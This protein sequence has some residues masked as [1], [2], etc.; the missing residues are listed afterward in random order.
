MKVGASSEYMGQEQI[1]QALQSIL[2]DRVTSGRIKN[3]KDLDTFWSVID[4][5]ALALRSVPFE[6]LSKVM[7]VKEVREI[8]RDVLVEVQNTPSR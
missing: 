2:E 3:Q 1:R 4:K 7:S 6:V 8:V 5:A